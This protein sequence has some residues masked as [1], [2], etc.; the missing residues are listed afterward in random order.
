[1]NS[2]GGGGVNGAERLDQRCAEY[3]TIQVYASDVRQWPLVRTVSEVVV[4]IVVVVVG[5]SGSGGS[6]IFARVGYRK[7]GPSRPIAL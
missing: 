6:G 5:T 1:M 4:V 2:G 7:E 3:G